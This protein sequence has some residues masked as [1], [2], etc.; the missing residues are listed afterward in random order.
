MIEIINVCFLS[1]DKDC[2]VNRYRPKKLEHMPETDIEKLE[3]EQIHARNLFNCSWEIVE[4][5]CAEKNVEDCNNV[6]IVVNKSLF[7]RYN[8]SNAF[9]MKSKWDFAQ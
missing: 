6:N 2:F 5:I 3:N 7:S 4:L 1:F 9:D 8:I